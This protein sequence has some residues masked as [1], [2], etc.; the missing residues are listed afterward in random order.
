MLDYPISGV[1]NWD[2]CAFG[3]GVGFFNAR[4]NATAALWHAAKIVGEDRP[5]QIRELLSTV[6]IA[7]VG[8]TE[9][10]YAWLRFAAVAVIR[11]TKAVTAN[12]RLR[13]WAIEV[14]AGA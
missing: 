5:A 4:F 13:F 14:A 7:C 2:K 10:V 3:V 9:A 12:A 11:A 8:P 6:T 1:A